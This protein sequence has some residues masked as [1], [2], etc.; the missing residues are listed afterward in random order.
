[1]KRVWRI[2]I[3]LLMTVLVAGS[4]NAAVNLSITPAS[5]DLERNSENQAYYSIAVR[6]DPTQAHSIE[7]LGDIFLTYDSAVFDVVVTADIVDHAASFITWEDSIINPNYPPPG[8]TL[9]TIHYGKT[10]SIGGNWS[11]SAQNIFSVH[12]FVKKDAVTGNTAVYFQADQC[13]I[14]DGDIHADVLGSVS[15]A[16]FNITLDNTAPISTAIPGGGLYKQPQ[17]VYMTTNEINNDAIV[18]F[19]TNNWSTELVTSDPT[20]TINIPGALAQVIIT[21]LNYYAEDNA[22]DKA[23]N[24]EAP[25]KQDVYIIDM[26]KP[27]INVTNYTTNVLGENDVFSITFT[28]SEPVVNYPSVTVGGVS[29]TAGRQ[30]GSSAG[31]FTY[32]R[33]ISGSE[34]PAGQVIITVTDLAGNEN[35]DSTVF[36]SLDFGGPIFTVTATPNPVDVETTLNID[37][38]AS[39]PLIATPSVVL[40][41]SVANLVSANEGILAY[42]YTVTVSGYGWLADL[43]ADNAPPEIY[44]FEAESEEDDQGEDENNTIDPDGAISFKIKDTRSGV[45]QSSITVYINSVPVIVSGS[46]K[47]GYS[48]SVVSDNYGV[49]SII[50]RSEEDFEPNKSLLIQ[51][52]VSDQSASGNVASVLFVLNISSGGELK[53]L[54]RALAIPTVFDP[55]DEETEIAYKLSKDGDIELRIYNVAGNLVWRRRY[56]SGDN[57]GM[58]GLNRVPWNGQNDYLAVL[59]NGVYMFYIIDFG[60]QNKTSV[61]ADGK[62]V[63]YKK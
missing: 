53:V 51:V 39:E 3:I 20:Y 31:P 16:T 9:K 58:K 30:S 35:T 1:M 7:A 2:V 45:N 24:V 26:E 32:T 5:G 43:G 36:A 10:N 62:V 28:I 22:L 34:D 4:V 44:D 27:V 6:V 19:T 63:I 55:R 25:I 54:D 33:T 59:S 57:G 38:T 56:D 52:Q 50:I 49:Y 12:F 13:H 61:L 60:E 29:Y 41:T 8:G 18:H 37:V 42:S 15:N 46:I 21:T 47:S 17:N 14:I 40:G 48:G 11:A 23:A